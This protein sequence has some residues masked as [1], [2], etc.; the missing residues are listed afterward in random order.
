VDFPLRDRELKLAATNAAWISLPLRDR[1]LKLTATTVGW[2]FVSGYRVRG[3]GALSSRTQ[4]GGLGAV[5]SARF[6]R[7]PRYGYIPKTKTF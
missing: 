6:S 5:G 4:T 3:N 1:G 2:A 7:P